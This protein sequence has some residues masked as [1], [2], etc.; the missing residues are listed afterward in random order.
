MLL[1]AAWHT[2]VDS[3]NSRS[4]GDG[5]GTPVGDGLPLCGP[6]LRDAGT[7]HAPAMRSLVFVVNPKSGG[8]RGPW[9][10]NRLPLRIAGERTMLL[11]EVDLNVLVA[12]LQPSAGHVALV[13][14]GGD[15]T[16]SAVLE[17]TW[18]MDPHA[19]IPVGLIPLGT[20]ND[21]ARVLGWQ[22][23]TLDESRLD[24]HLHGLQSAPIGH[25]D[26]WVLHG[27]EGSRAF[28]N[29]LSLGGDARIAAR[30][31]A[32]RRHHGWLARG[33]L[34]NRALYGLAGLGEPAAPLRGA[35]TG[36]DLPTWSRS[37]VF[38]NIPSYAGGTCLARGIS[39]GDGLLDAVALGPGAAMAAAVAGLRRP[40]HL[41]RQAV[42]RFTL[43][44]PVVA[45]IDGEPTRLPAGDHVIAS[46]GSWRVLLG[47][48]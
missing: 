22:R 19:P 14:C 1:G 7:H 25:L 5:Q 27:P 9:L 20:G 37:L 39:A 41:G 23:G 28:G 17:A 15:G 42:W 18:R 33:P 35:L 44:R 43:E 48:G 32:I 31:D 11:G 24:H 38:A 29:Y 4:K 46:G 13:A 16:A 10:L 21:L 3:W 12:S 45:Q 30:F 47:H 40:R 26:R 8:R 6:W 36:L 34:I 2:V